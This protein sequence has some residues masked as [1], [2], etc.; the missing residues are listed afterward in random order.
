LNFEQMADFGFWEEAAGV[1]GFPVAGWPESAE[2]AHQHQQ[3]F[4]PLPFGSRQ[5][6]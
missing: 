3:A 2:F 1:Q 6:M 5:D 4:E